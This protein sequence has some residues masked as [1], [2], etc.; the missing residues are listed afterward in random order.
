MDDWITKYGRHNGRLEFFS[1]VHITPFFSKIANPL[2]SMK[3]TG[4]VSVERAAKPL[5]NKL[6]TNDRNR[7]DTNSRSLLLR[8][9]INLQFKAAHMGQAEDDQVDHE[10]IYDA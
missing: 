5:K 7:M 10:L 6:A 8:V 4:S 3:T 2:L 9:G 1:G